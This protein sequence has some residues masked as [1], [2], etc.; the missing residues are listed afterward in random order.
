M[1][2]EHH[3]LGLPWVGAQEQHPAVTEPDMRHL[4]RDGHPVDQHDLVAPV[5]LVRLARRE[6]QRHERCRRRRGLPAPPLSRVAPHRVVAPFIAEPAQVLKNPQ[7]RHSLA[8]LAR[9]IHRQQLVQILQPPPELRL[10]L[11]AA[12][13][14]ERRL[15]RAQDLAHRI[16]G[17]VQLPRDLP[18]RPAAHKVLAANPRD[19]VHALHPPAT[20]PETRTGSLCETRRGGSILD[21]DPAAHR[22]N[23]PRRSTP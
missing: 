1:G 16:P 20:R 9:C 14:F 6:A 19:R 3:L 12:L 8:S 7:Q 21:A 11:H 18:D 23:I 10:G 22:V 5:E 4:H 13:V 2:I 15:T 17:D